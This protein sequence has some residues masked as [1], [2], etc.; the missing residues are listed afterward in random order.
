[1]SFFEG[2]HLLLLVFVTPF[3]LIASLGL[4]K[5]RFREGIFKAV[6]ITFYLLLSLTILSVIT[7][8]TFD[9]AIQII[10]RTSLCLIFSL[11][12]FWA[13]AGEHRYTTSHL[14]E[15]SKKFALPVWIISLILLIICFIAKPSLLSEISE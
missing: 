11:Y 9:Q 6:L 3:Y 15:K 4:F 14:W 8:S 13:P 12:F 1:M 2:L 10:Y 5:T 7:A